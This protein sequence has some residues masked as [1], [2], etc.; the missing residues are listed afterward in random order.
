MRKTLFE[1]LN[2][3]CHPCLIV[4][5]AI[6][7]PIQNGQ[8]TLNCVIKNTSSP[9][10]LSFIANG[11]SP[12]PARSQPRFECLWPG[13]QS[14]GFGRGR[15]RGH[16]RWRLVM[17]VMTCFWWRNWVYFDHFVLVN[18]WQ[19]LRVNM[20]GMLYLSV[21]IEFS[22]FCCWSYGSDNSTDRKWIQRYLDRYHK[23]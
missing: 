9:S 7:S 23:S 15:G 3:T 5:S 21:R 14:P 2:T 6:C 11:P 4:T 17:T 16:L 13:T 20:D 12:S 1:H 18:K 19:M 22:A 8:S 10:S